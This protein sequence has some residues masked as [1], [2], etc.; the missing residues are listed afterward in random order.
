MFSCHSINVFVAFGQ[1]IKNKA[2]TR[3]TQSIK[4]NKFNNQI[5]YIPVINFILSKFRLVLEVY[6]YNFKIFIVFVVLL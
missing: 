1:A 4:E 2:R 6:C 5:I 3:R